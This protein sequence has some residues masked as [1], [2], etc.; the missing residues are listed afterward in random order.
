MP[1]RK[2]LVSVIGGHKCDKKTA[3]LAE[4]VGKIIAE[5]KAILVCGGLSGV[6]EAACKGAKEAGGV[7]IG[8]IPGEDKEDAIQEWNRRVDKDAV[9]EP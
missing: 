8:I 2:I 5:Q 1:V 9:Q 6:M 4:T 7:T 3:N